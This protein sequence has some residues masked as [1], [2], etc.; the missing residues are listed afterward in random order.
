MDSE[1]D[2]NPHFKLTKE[3]QVA[4]D[5]LNA[6]KTFEKGTILIAKGD[7]FKKSYYVLKGCIRKYYLIDGE[8]K[9]TFFYTEN[10]TVL[11]SKNDKNDTSKFYLECIE[12]TTC[13]VTT[14]AQEEAL[15][16]RFPRFQELCRITTEKELNKYQ[17]MFDTYMISTPEQR[18]LKLLK[19]NKDLINRVPQYQLASYLGVKPESLSR[20]RKRIFLKK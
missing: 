16:K 1:K 19:N 15:Y 6:E 3:E 5:K 2:N 4:I 17:E 14:Y 18:Y 20:I 12:E 10:Q 13:S 9:T 11:I 7:Q 8:E